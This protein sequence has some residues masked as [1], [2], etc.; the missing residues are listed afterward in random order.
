MRAKIS[1]GVQSKTAENH[2]SF[3]PYT[4]QPISLK[5]QP[6]LRPILGPFL[7]PCSAQKEGSDRS[8]NQSPMQQPIFL[9]FLFL[10]FFFS[11]LF[12]PPLAHHFPLS[13]P[14]LPAPLAATL[15]PTT[16]PV[17]P[18][19]YHFPFLLPCKLPSPHLPITFPFFLSLFRA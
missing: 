3:R 11:F 8:P 10:F 18:V 15:P 19:S 5:L 6:N 4:S 14:M 2:C 9:F 17:Q 1:K 12:F 7:G 16:S 13:S